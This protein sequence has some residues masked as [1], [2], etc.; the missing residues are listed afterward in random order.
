MKDEPSTD[1]KPTARELGWRVRRT[2]M[3]FLDRRF[4]VRQYELSVPRREETIT[5]THVERAPGILI[6]PVTANGDIILIRQYRF[7]VD[8]WLWEIPAGSTSDT[9]DTPLEE[10]IAK[11]LREEIGAVAERLERIGEFFP[12]PAYSTEK[13]AVY[14]AWETRFEGEAEPEPTEYIELA[15]TPASEALRMAEAGE[16]TNGACALALLLCRN[17]LIRAGCLR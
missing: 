7:P 14:I 12:S 1:S 13:C 3:P 9:G 8:A 15:P 10:V 17:A 4:Q 2:S 11:E 5:F 16:I 6:V